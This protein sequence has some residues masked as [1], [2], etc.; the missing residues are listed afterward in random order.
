MDKSKA[1][2]LKIRLQILGWSLKSQTYFSA[3]PHT[4]SLLLK[5]LYPKWHMHITYFGLAE[6][7]LL[8]CV[9]VGDLHSRRMERWSFVGQQFKKEGNLNGWGPT[10]H[11]TTPDIGK[12]ARYWNTWYTWYWKDCNFSKPTPG[13]KPEGLVCRFCCWEMQANHFEFSPL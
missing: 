6:A 3:L 11:P 13:S 5:A 1:P 12:F 4:P 7:Q 8:C 2:L 10:C 9:H